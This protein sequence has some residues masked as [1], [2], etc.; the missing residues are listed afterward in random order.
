MPRRLQ[1]QSSL[2]TSE[3][4]TSGIERGPGLRTHVCSGGPAQHCSLPIAAPFSRE[5]SE[6]LQ[7]VQCIRD[8]KAV[9]RQQVCGQTGR[10]QGILQPMSR[11][12][13]QKGTFET[14][15]LGARGGHKDQLDIGACSVRGGRSRFLPGYG[16]R[17][18]ASIQAVEMKGQGCDNN[19]GSLE[20][21]SSLV[22]SL[23]GQRPFS[24]LFTCPAMVIASDM[25]KYHHV[26]WGGC[27]L[28]FRQAT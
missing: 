1:D 16:L 6:K 28:A 3:N 18:E 25:V 20:Q 7:I 5:S 26:Y 23:T 19:P 13:R 9:K 21:R 10:P 11:S 24:M 8:Q 27:A 12:S 15:L 14:W 22:L 17:E 4:K 2:D